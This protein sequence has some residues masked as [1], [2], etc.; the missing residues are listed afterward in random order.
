MSLR[1]S[2]PGI[3]GVTSEFTSDRRTV[4]K[5]RSSRRARI[6]PRMAAAGA[7]SPLLPERSILLHIGPHKT[8]TTS[9]QDAFFNQRDALSSQGVHYA[10]HGPKAADAVRAVRNVRAPNGKVPPMR[11]WQALAQEARGAAGA[12]VV[13]SNEFLSD[14][15]ESVVE[16][17][18]TD[19]DARRLH[20][21]ATLRPLDRILPSQWQQF[22]QGG[23]TTP[24]DAWLREVLADPDTPAKGF[25]RR[26]R[27]DHL[28]AR[29]ADVLGPDRVTV[30]VVDERDPG[31]VLRAF[32]NLLGLRH[33]TLV[34]ALDQRNRS[35][36]WA[37]IEAVRALNLALEPHGIDRPLQ[38]RLIQRGACEAIKARVPTS[39]ELRVTL[40]GW[41]AERAAWVAQAVVEGIDATG[42]RVIGD[43][44]DLARPTSPG[45]GDTSTPTCVD[46]AIAARLSMGIL[47]ALGIRRGGRPGVDA[48]ELASVPTM[49]LVS[50][51]A[52]R[53]GRAAVGRLRG[54]TGGTSR[55]GGAAG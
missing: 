27:H 12:R 23:L 43:L 48:P 7:P 31:Q 10:G 9:V 53:P 22:V 42:V 18:A 35:M 3:E 11:H 29:W 33:G 6:L 49:R 17:I 16:T 4:P 26:H 55:P 2:Q 1:R 21:V 28:V 50:A 52:R 38:Y 45:V 8:A 25:W 20:I 15:P 40:P 41:A 54:R 47:E 51:I 14:A 36:T 19:L 44:R 32:E 24:F 5:P 13:I 37:E 34:A 39:G 46:P 30:V